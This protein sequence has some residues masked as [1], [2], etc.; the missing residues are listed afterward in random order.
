[1]INND[2]TT[3]SA[4]LE[5]RSPSSPTVE[6]P[7]AAALPRP[8]LG[9]ML[10]GDLGFIPVLLTLIV[11]ALFF[12]I[13]TG[14]VFFEPR[15]ISNL[16]VQISTIATLSVGVTLVL[17]L[18]EIDLSLAS[19]SVLAGV[20][21]GILSER[22]HLPAGIAIIAAILSGSVIGLLNGVIIAIIRVPSFIV[23]LAASIAYEGLLLYLL[24][25]QSTL[26]LNDPFINAISGS[27]T[28]YLPDLYGVGL[29]TLVLL[30]YVGSLIITHIRRRQTGLKTVSLAQFVAQIVIT[31]VLVEGTVIL[32]ESYL[33][34]PYAAAI[35]IVLVLLVWLMLTKTPLGRHIYA[36]GGNAEAARRAGINVVGIRLVVFTLCSTIAAIG[37]IMAASHANSVASQISATLL[38]QAIAAAVIGGVSL[39]GGRGSVWSILLGALIIGSLENGLD[40]KSQ[41][42]EVKDMI[43]GVVLVLAVI[44]DAL[45]R[46]AQARSGR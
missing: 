6:V 4:V 1:M 19:V 39:F 28:S 45:V 21:M 33:G 31:V 11:V 43:E 26:I 23:T 7:S 5:G 3:G 24:A 40:L 22:A 46:R 2:E 32:F 30:L 15:N 36:V 27:A 16:V 13:T 41:G 9:Q 34:V 35:L 17:L 42:T 20:V 8:S 25:G 10:R 12:G 38:L 44:V 29:P 18:G 37:G 14:G